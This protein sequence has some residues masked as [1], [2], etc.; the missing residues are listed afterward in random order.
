MGSIVGEP[1][2]RGEARQREPDHQDEDDPVG[3]WPR[4]IET[5]L[6]GDHDGD[7]AAADRSDDV[8]D[9]Q[10]RELEREELA[11]V[12]GAAVLGE[13]RRLDDEQRLLAGRIHGGQ[14]GEPDGRRGDDEADRGER[15]E[16]DPAR[17]HQA[18]AEAIGGRADRERD[19]RRREV[20]DGGDDPD[21]RGIDAE[22]AQVEV[23]VDPV[24][25]DR[26]AGDE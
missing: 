8:R 9:V 15:H 24:E 10:D 23:E 25:A 11:A 6:A 14:E 1:G 19:E 22:R 2:E 7:R 26:R 3:T 16:P 18:A 5:Q 4:G 20:R 21:D 12:L 17:H 13:V